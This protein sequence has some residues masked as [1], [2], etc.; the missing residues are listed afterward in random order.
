MKIR[1][2]V[3]KIL[4]GGLTFVEV[5][6][7]HISG[8]QMV[9]HIPNCNLLTNKLGLLQSLQSHERINMGIRGREPRYKVLDL[10]PETYR[11][12]DPKEREAF[13]DNH[14]GQFPASILMSN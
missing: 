9:N 14:K 11:L 6:I 3:L 7:M 13:F 8:E 2:V 10:L 12:D 1:T 5:F 4:G